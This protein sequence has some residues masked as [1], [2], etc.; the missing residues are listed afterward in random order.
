MIRKLDLKQLSLRLCYGSDR[1]VKA[2][3]AK[4]FFS[5][6]PAAKNEASCQILTETG[7]TDYP[8]L[9]AFM[10]RKF[11]SSGND[12][13][14]F[15]W[16]GV[17][18]RC[19][20]HQILLKYCPLRNILPASIKTLV[21]GFMSL[22]PADK[23][24]SLKKVESYYLLAY[25]LQNMFTRRRYEACFDFLLQLAEKSRAEKIKYPS[26]HEDVGLIL[27]IRKQFSLFI[28]ERYFSS[29]ALKRT[30]TS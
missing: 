20:P 3:L 21:K 6:D 15:Y 23:K 4:I 24:L 28:E 12:F 9:A 10:A 22:I 1:L 2:E 7:V 16:W 29:T 11:T 30:A 17:A 25:A 27:L 26:L 14:A 19:Y 8:E 5:D 13:K 18:L